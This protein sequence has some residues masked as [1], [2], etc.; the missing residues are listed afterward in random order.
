MIQ[1]GFGGADMTNQPFLYDE[2]HMQI[3]KIGSKIDNNIHLTHAV[4]N[5]N[6]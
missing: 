3:T 6:E 4:L 2:L 1:G 5:I